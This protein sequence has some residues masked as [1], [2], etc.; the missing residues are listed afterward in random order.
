MY[1]R[2]IGSSLE[3]YKYLEL[4]YNDYR[5]LKFKNRQGKL[6]LS[7]VDE[8]VDDLLRNDRVCNVILPRLQKRHILEETEQIE[9]RRNYDYYSIYQYMGF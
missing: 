1:L 5:K 9:P 3:C 8:F 4:L 7:H 6:T 2:L